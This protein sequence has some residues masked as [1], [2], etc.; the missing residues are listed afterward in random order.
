M[1]RN[2]IFYFLFL[3]SATAFFSC[4]KEYSLETG[5]S[6][7]ARGSLHD[8]AGDCFSS[9]VKGT[10]FT[11]VTV[12]GSSYI[13]LQV[14]VTTPGSYR[15]ASDTVNG[16]SFEN[17]GVFT[18]TGLQTIKLQASGKPIQVEISNF[19]I[20]FDSTICLF[21]VNVQDSTGVGTG[22]INNSDSAWSFTEGSKHFNGYIDTAFTY[23]TVFTGIPVRIL[24][25]QGATAYTGD[26]LFL[27]SIAFPAS[28]V[29]TGT[30]STTT[31]A[32]FRY[33]GSYNIDDTIYSAS[34]LIPT[35]NTIVN[36]SAYSTST[37]IV[38]GTLSGTAKNRAGT[39]VNITL[40]KFEAKLN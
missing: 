12:P 22:G 19:F 23:D 37:R 18:A 30:F 9:S 33:L 8:D 21:S 14:N 28:N 4:S 2:L 10:Y 15:I 24:Q 40:G 34:P 29:T 26:S 16:F 32:A 7:R 27:V 3:F 25:I 13:E 20:S 38:K 1:N 6:T 5:L 31:T 11:G 39:T 35:V 36:I 17:S